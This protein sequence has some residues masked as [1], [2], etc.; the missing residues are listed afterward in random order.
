MTTPFA[1]PAPYLLGLA[2][3]ADLTKKVL[4]K[5]VTGCSGFGTPLQELLGDAPGVGQ[6]GVDSLTQQC[7]IICELFVRL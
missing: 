5:F 7:S 6:E 3:I 1:G 2:V 4:N